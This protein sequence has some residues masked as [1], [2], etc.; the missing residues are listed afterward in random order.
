M[1]TAK[2]L[3]D[4]EKLQKECEAHDKFQLKLNWEMLRNRGTDQFDFL[5][6][7]KEELIA[8]IGI[9]EFGSTA[10]VCGMVKPNERR[11]GYFT[12]LFNKAK[13]SMANHSFKRILL[14]APATSDAAKGFLA[15]QGASYKNSEHQMHW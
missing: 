10:E 9:Y 1:L 13:L 12:E 4:I 6:Y 11:K 7:E 8:F 5:L 14:N 2:Q 3:V 15:T